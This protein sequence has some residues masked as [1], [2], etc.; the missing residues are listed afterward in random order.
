MPKLDKSR[1][2]ELPTKGKAI[3]KGPMASELMEKATRRRASNQ[4]SNNALA[5]QRV[6]N[7]QMEKDRLTGIVRDNH[8]V[9]LQDKKPL[10]LRARILDDHIKH[11]AP[12]VGIHGMYR[13][14]QNKYILH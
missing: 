9:R 8:L 10:E 12:L 1:R 14:R 2:G 11:M 13:R 4:F 3:K 5:K 6:A 7:Y